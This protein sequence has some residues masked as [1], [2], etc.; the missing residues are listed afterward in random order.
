[1]AMVIDRLWQPSNDDHGQLVRGHVLSAS[2]S[3]LDCIS[4][5]S[6]ATAESKRERSAHGRT[7]PT[8]RPTA[9]T[10]LGFPEWE[11]SA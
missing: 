11:R 10:A 3:R 1:M 9:A 4:R 6:K 7:L 8:V 5:R 2:N